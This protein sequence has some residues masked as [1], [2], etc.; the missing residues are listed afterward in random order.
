MR[1]CGQLNVRKYKEIKDSDERVTLNMYEIL[2]I[3]EEFD[4]LDKME[5]TSSESKVKMEGSG[6]WLVTALALNTK[7]RSKKY[8]EARYA[9]GNVSMK[10]LSNKIKEF[11]KN[12]KVTYLKR[13]PKHEPTSSYFHLVECLGKCMM[14]SGEDN[15]HVHDGYGQDMAP[16]SDVNDTDEDKDDDK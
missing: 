10:D 3:P 15:H 16:S 4:D 14:R 12:V 7:A 13:T 8:K 2:K 6:K 5:T 11:E 9:I 1:N